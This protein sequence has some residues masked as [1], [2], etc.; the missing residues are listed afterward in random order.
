MSPQLIVV[1]GYH[2]SGPNHWQTW[3]ERQRPAAQ[4]VRGIDWER[5]KLATWA[6]AVR[7]EI[8]GASRPVLLVAHS[9]GCLATVVAAADQ[10]EKIAGVIFV[11]PADPE[12]FQQ[13]LTQ[14]LPDCFLG[15]QS[16]LIA[17]ENDP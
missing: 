3:L 16:V 6:Q 7:N 14:T 8:D 4:R 12:R 11:A 10:V 5:P 1:P 13:G 2:G 15:F 17:S 9:F